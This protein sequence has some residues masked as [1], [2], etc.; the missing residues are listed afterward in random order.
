MHPRTPSRFICL[1]LAVLGLNILLGCAAFRQG[2]QNAMQKIRGINPVDDFYDD[3][4]DEDAPNVQKAAGTD[5]SVAQPSKGMISKGSFFD[6]PAQWEIVKITKASSRYK[7]K[8][9]AGENA[10]MVVTRVPWDGDETQRQ[11]A[12]RQS[13]QDIIGQ[14]PSVYKKKDYREWIA[15]DDGSRI[16]TALE[17]RKADD[18]PMMTIL[19]YSV[20]IKKDNYMVFAAFPSKTSRKED[21]LFLVD[22]LRPL[23][24]PTPKPVP[25]PEATAESVA[26][27]AAESAAESTTDPAP[28]SDEAPDDSPKLAPEESPDAATQP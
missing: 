2:T 17:G 15:D 19:G 18:A 8:H 3:E 12:L 4:D 26:D 27:S 23:T 6:I 21:I 13:H 25:E 28:P 24:E 20:G 22:S 11:N 7:L 5:S 9:S 10:S 14:M 1:V 16:M